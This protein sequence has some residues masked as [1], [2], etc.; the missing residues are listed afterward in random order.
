MTTKLFHIS[1]VHF[2]VENRRALDAVAQGVK[3]ECPDALVCTGDITQRAK[4]SEYAAAA[5][6]FRQFDVPVWLDPGNHD[7][8]YYNLWERFT[9]P[10][11]RFRRLRENVA[12]DH[13]ETD[14]L[15]LVPLNTNVPAQGRWP[16]SDGV[17]KEKAQ[18]KTRDLLQSY[19]DDERCLI[20]TAHHPLHGPQEGGPSAT[21][22]GNAAL[23]T[24]TDCGMDAIMTG[25]IHMPFDELRGSSQRK[26]KV[27][28]AGTL[29]TRL[30]HG[31]PPSYNV[32]T[33]QRGL[34]G[35][36][37]TIEVELRSLENAI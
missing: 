29:S 20:V 21:I 31:A 12:V 22:G 8:P 13:F 28:G 18:V 33:C 17:V 16:W 34:P 36:K 7:M 4:H 14:D 5:D 37:H 26:A 32:I 23:Q 30:R 2:G 25:H 24:L 11:G 27:I 10:F 15:I 9:D 6:W 3:E 1:D 19:A 35:L